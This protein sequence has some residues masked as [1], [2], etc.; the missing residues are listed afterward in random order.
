MKIYLV[1]NVRIPTEKAHGYQIAKTAESLAMLGHEVELIVPTR[2]NK[3]N[4]DIYSYYSIKKNFKIFYIKSFDFFVLE[5]VLGSKLSFYLQ[6]LFFKFQISNFKFQITEDSA[7]ITRNPE[8]VASIRKKGINVFFDAHRWPESKNGIYKKMLK[9]ADGVICNSFG[10]EREYNI[11]GFEKTIALP[12]GV[13]L[14]QYE[15]NKADQE[16]RANL[17]LPAA[18][19][20]ALYVGHLYA[21]KGAEVI[22]DCAA[23]MKNEKLFFLLAGGTEKDIAAYQAKI[24]ERGLSNV[25]LLGHKKK[26]DIPGLQ[27]SADVL[28]LPNIP[29]NQESD[30]F[31]SPIKMFEY[32]AAGVPIV[33]S[34]LP[35]IREILN[36][37]NASLVKAG[38]AL[39]MAEAIRSLIRDKA[40]GLARSTRA[41]ADVEQ[42]SWENRARKMLGFMTDTAY[43]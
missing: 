4:E 27:M 32:M 15:K 33:A 16:I 42:Y 39:A 34:D 5:K 21:W 3:A 29:V 28:L 40:R 9:P 41:R 18:W 19:R 35:S 12:N 1:H 30:R 6:S 13:D 7:A 22:L 14:E 2:K 36:E 23:I 20:L 25:R 11:N 43:D 10:T 24:N 38:D 26:A 8:L 17:G 31:T 37:E